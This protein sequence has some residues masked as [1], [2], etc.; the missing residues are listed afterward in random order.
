MHAC[1]R[2]LFQGNWFSQFKAYKKIF[3]SQR[4]PIF[5]CSGSIARLNMKGTMY[6]GLST[7]QER[8]EK[9]ADPGSNPGRSTNVAVG[10]ARAP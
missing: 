8:A 2:S 9:A 6:D 10:D 7:P 4:N 5:N 1:S 3:I